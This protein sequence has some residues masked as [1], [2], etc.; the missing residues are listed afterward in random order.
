MLHD[1]YKGQTNH[2]LTVQTN[3]VW[4]N[5]RGIQLGDA[6]DGANTRA[7]APIWGEDDHEHESKTSN[8]EQTPARFSFRLPTDIVWFDEM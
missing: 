5:R 7:T 2:S 4:I 6:F 1:H 8:L 3:R